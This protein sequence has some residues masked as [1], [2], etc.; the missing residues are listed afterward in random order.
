M[1]DGT[2][3]ICTEPIGTIKKRLLDCLNIVSGDE[4]SLVNLDY[5]SRSTYESGEYR[6]WFSET[7]PFA[8][9]TPANAKSLP[10]GCLFPPC[11]GVRGISV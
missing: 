8:R 6:V 1:K 9:V 4:L 3:E 2:H 7:L 5:L 11:V 10:R